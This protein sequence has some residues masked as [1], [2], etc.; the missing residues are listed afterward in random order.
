MSRRSSRVAD[1]IRAELSQI[2][3]RKLQDPRVKLATVSG[4]DISPDLKH[5]VVQMSIVGDESQRQQ[6]IEALQHAK[7]FLRS[8]LA[9]ELHNMKTIPD[10]RF[11]LDRGA[12]YS[13]RISDLLENPDE[14]DNESP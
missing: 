7:G 9:R 14:H 6:A 12:E 1:L 8:Q 5:A 10:L 4:I 2:L 13:Q 3:L 11:E